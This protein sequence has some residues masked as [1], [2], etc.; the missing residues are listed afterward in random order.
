MNYFMLYLH[1]CIYDFFLRFYNMGV[2]DQTPHCGL[3]ASCNRDVTS[4]IMAVT[5]V[6]V[7][8]IITESTNHAL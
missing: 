5:D 4:S 1:I 8:F 3:I 7:V 2:C 6:A